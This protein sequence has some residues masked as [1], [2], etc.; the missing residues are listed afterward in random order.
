MDQLGSGA[1]PFD[2]GL[3]KQGANFVPLTPLSFLARAAKAFPRRPAHV[4][5]SAVTSYERFYARCRRLASALNRRGIGVGDTV[6]IMAPNTPPLLEAH[7]GVA[8]SGAVLNALNTQLD[9][10]TLR[11][12]LDRGDVKVLLTDRAF[13][14]VINDA[15]AKA[16][17]RPLIIDIDDAAIDDGAFLGETDYES[18]LAE[19]DPEFA[20]RQPADEW[21]PISL[22]FTSG[23]TGRPK[24]AVYHHRGAY[25]KAIGN[26][27][28]WNM[29]DGPVYLW[30]W[31]MFHCNGLCFP[32]TVTAY[33]GTQVCL[34]EADPGAVFQAI[35]DHQVSHFC[36]P[37]DLLSKLANAAD[38]LKRPTDQT[39]EVMTA[40]SPPPAAVIEKMENHGFRVTHS[41]GLTEVLGSVAVC[42]WQSEWDGRPA[43]ERAALKARQGIAYPTMED[44]AVVDPGT[45][46]PVPADGRTIGEVIMRGN[47]VM[48]GYLDDRDQTNRGFKDGWFHTGDLGVVHEDRYIELRDR[49][50]DIVET[51]DGYVS[52][53]EIENELYQHPAVLEAAVVAVPDDMNG[54]APCAFVALKPGARATAEELK[55]FCAAAMSAE[56]VPRDVIFEALPRTSTGKV[57]KYELRRKAAAFDGTP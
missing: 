11:Y 4:Y 14:P 9:A 21:D 2:A 22:T 29:T 35:A 44:L 48:A 18:L 3:G 46:K 49:A 32:W 16:K 7:F 30:T 12:V 38:D 19:G 1:G 41:Y 40:G 26:G 15:F 57:K 34:R 17:T 56:K 45:F 36:A 37:P 55:K 24:G 10:D 31:P 39:V 13:S 27:M 42:T 25:L 33:A 52:T 43:A 23:T 54:Q 50:A 5:G 51:T 53:I 8:M 6:A 28:A 20:W 47:T